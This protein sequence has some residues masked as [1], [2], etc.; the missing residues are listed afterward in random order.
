MSVLETRSPGGW[1]LS[2]STVVFSLLHYRIV[3]DMTAD[4]VSGRLRGVGCSSSESASRR[5]VV[6]VVHGA[7][8]DDSQFQSQRVEMGKDGGNQGRGQCVWRRIEEHKCHTKGGS[9]GL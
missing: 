3:L 6:V 9:R 7:G 8:G 4:V 1:P 2:L 5:R